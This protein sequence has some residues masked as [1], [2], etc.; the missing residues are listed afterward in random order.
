M[1]QGSGILF[2]VLAIE[3]IDADPLRPGIQTVHIDINTIR[4]GTRGIKG[5][6]AAGFTESVFGNAGIKTVAAKG[7]FTGE[8]IKFTQRHY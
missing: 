7:F 6:D 4:I 5:F 8:Q 2:P 1:G 3:F